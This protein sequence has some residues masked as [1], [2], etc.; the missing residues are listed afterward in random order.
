[1]YSSG[2][3]SWF[4]AREIS[5]WMPRGAKRFGS[6]LVGGVVDREVRAVAE[7]GRLPAEDA[8]AR[9]VEGED[10]DP[11]RRVAEQALEPVAHLVRGAVREGDREDLV[12]LRA[13]RADQVGDAMGEHAR[14]ARARSR[15]D[16][17]R[18]LRG[19]DGLALGGIQVGE[20]RLGRS[21]GHVSDSSEGAC[22]RDR[23]RRDRS[24]SRP[25][26]AFG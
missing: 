5:A 16:E 2:P 15:D 9:G 6:N 3:T 26:D 25:R 20:E 1:L 12:R 8:P 10:P 7:P 13:D 24:D 17:Q 14:L 19:E 4:F 22:G 23:R 18:P 11:P 21:D